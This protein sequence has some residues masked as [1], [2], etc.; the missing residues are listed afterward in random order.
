MKLMGRIRTTWIKNFA[1]ELVEK[2][3]D[4]ITKSFEDNKKLLNEINILEDKVIRN[5][6]A[7][8]AATLAKKSK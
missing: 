2:Y 7:G 8:Y 3:P 5:R 6:V 4:R 1:R